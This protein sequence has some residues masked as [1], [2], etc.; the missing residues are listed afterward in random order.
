MKTTVYW[1]HMNHLT[2]ALETIGFSDKEGRAYVALL[3]LGAATPYRVAEK[4]G[5]KRPTAYVVCEELVRKNA[6]VRVPGD[7]LRYIARTPETVIEDAERAARDL[8]RLLPEF[9]SLDKGTREKQRILSYEGAEGLRQAYRYR[10]EDLHGKEIVGFYSKADENTPKDVIEVF[11]EWNTYKEKHQTRVR[12]LSVDAPFLKDFQQFLQPETTMIRSKYLP[13]ELY[14]A[15]ASIES[16]GDFVRICLTD[17][18][19]ALIIESPKFA[20]A[21]RQV[22]ELVWKSLEGKYDTPKNIHLPK[23]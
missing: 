15:K 23:P 19:Q 10:Q 22:F 11:Q 12:S 9:R 14:D 8:R 17:S 21:L 2:T 6:I 3:Q 16:C 7:E 5:L 13:P 4:A 1:S 18:A 20:D